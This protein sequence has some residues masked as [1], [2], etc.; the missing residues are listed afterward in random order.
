MT[1]M[2][3][4]SVISSMVVDGAASPSQQSTR[5][6]DESTLQSDRHGAESESQR[7]SFDDA[8][9]V[10]QDEGGP[11]H[12]GEAG[13]GGGTVSTVPGLPNHPAE[14]AMPQREGETNEEHADRIRF[15]V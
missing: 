4:A 8:A 7:P 10:L 14:A 6:S 3:V 13:G 1:S 9:E 2:G 5:H 12:R 15:W 11:R